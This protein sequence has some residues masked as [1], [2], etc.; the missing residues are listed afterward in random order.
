MIFTVVPLA[1][2]EPPPY[3]PGRPKPLPPPEPP[4]PRPPPEPPQPIPPDDATSSSPSAPPLRPLVVLGVVAVALLAL[5]LRLR[6]PLSSPIIGAEDP[7]AHMA[8]TWDLGRG[9]LDNYPPGL[10]MLMLPFTMLGP[11]TFYQVARFIP[12]LAGVSLAVG[13]FF[14]CRRWMHPAG[15]ITAAALVAVMPETIRRTD[16]L[17]PTAVDLALLP[18]LFLLVL[19]AVDGRRAAAIGAVVLAVVLL[20]VHPWVFALAAPPLLVVTFV[21]AAR[22]HRGWRVP[23]AIAGGLVLGAI[24]AAL[25]FGS[26]IDL[27]MRHA[28]PHL[29][30]LIRNPASLWPPPV[31]VDLPA[32]LTIPALVVAG[33]G[34]V[35]AVVHRNRLTLLALAWSLFLLPLV[36]VDWFDVWYLPHRTA[37][38]LALGI[39]MLGGIAVSGFASLFSNADAKAR[40][41]GVAVAVLIV[42]GLA[43]PAGAATSPWYRIYQADDYTAWHD[44]QARSAPYVVAGS[45]QSQMGYAAVTGRSA[46]F[47]P[48]FFSDSS[49]RDFRLRQHPDLVVLV[50][51]YALESGTP[52]AFL[53][54]WHLVA[55]W[56]NGTLSAYT[57]N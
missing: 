45:W 6:D 27:V 1:E 3:P 55:Q 53:S 36:L 48:T 44:L 54:Q 32:M 26:P 12:V 41:T 23:L 28:W 16:V 15:A 24:I 19:L 38:Y 42:V 34:A 21:V 57:R 50:D 40:N 2:V 13:T 14:L 10:A 52:T 29:Q 39:A 37:A 46:V 43:V 49:D 8:R 18:W 56:G 20:A 11:A 9:Q 47:D 5:A 22:Q 30:Q 33:A 7:Y 31:F 35:V 4:E 25:K 17:F 51:H